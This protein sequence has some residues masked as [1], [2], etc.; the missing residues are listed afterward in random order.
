MI[1]INN[2]SKKGKKNKRLDYKYYFSLKKIQLYIGFK[3]IN[4]KVLIVLLL[5][6]ACLN[7]Y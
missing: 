5:L 7:F 4:I 1:M 6:K 3:I 2:S